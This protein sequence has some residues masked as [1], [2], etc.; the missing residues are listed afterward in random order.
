MHIPAYNQSK[1]TFPLSAKPQ[2]KPDGVPNKATSMEAPPQAVRF[3]L[4]LCRAKEYAGWDSGKSDENPF[5]AL[6]SFP[7]CKRFSFRY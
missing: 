2:P 3:W 1:A 7:T 5:L 6:F 4:R